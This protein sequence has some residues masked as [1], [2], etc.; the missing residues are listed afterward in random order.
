MLLPLWADAAAVLRI[1]AANMIANFFIVCF[2][3]VSFIFCIS[4]SQPLVKESRGE[5][6]AVDRFLFAPFQE[7]GGPL[8]LGYSRIRDAL[9]LAD[10]A[11]NQRESLLHLR[12]GLFRR[13]EGV[14]R[15]A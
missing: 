8:H 15:R 3:R 4:V 5:N 14:G 2:L 12:I 13:V 9:P 1:I 11:A 10:L 6:N 7:F